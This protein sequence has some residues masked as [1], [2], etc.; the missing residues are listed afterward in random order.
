MVPVE[1]ESLLLV[2]E[3]KGSLLKLLLLSPA[4]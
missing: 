1:K 2:L 4:G 3:E